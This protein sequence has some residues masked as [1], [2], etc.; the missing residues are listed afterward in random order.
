MELI[1]G[2]VRDNTHIKKPFFHQLEALKK[3]ESFYDDIT[4]KRSGLISIPTGGGKTFTAVRWIYSCVI[5]K[6]IKVIWLVHSIHLLEQAR[7]SFED[8]IGVLDDSINKLSLKIVSSNKLHSSD[9]QILEDDDILIITTPTAISSLKADSSDEAG[10][11][12]RTFIQKHQE[13]GILFVIDE[14]HHVP[15]YGC[16]NLLLNIKEDYKN[17]WMLGLT[18]TPTYTDINKRGW[19]G[20]IFDGGIIYGI[21]V[22]ILQKQ[23][24]LAKEEIFYKK[25]PVVMEVDEALFDR[26]VRKHKDIPEDIIE[27]LA[28]STVRNEF[29]ASEYAANKSYYGKTIIFLDRWFQCMH[30]K[31]LLENAG[32]RAEAVYYQRD[33]DAAKSEIDDNLQVIKNFKNNEFEVLLNIRML[34][35]G[36]DIPDVKTVFITRD[37]TSHILLQQMIGRALRG[38]K[39]GGGKNKSSAKI[40]MVGDTW[41]RKIEW[42]TPDLFGGTD[43]TTKVTTKLPV[44]HISYSLVQAL[45]KQLGEGVVLQR[46]KYVDL[47]PMGWYIT[48]FVVAFSGDDESLQLYKEYVLAYKNSK[49]ALD[50]MIND[51]VDFID[52]RWAA[53]SLESSFIN[54]EVKKLKRQYLENIDI[55]KEDVVR[56]CRHVAQNNTA[57]IFISFDN[58]ED[59]DLDRITYDMLSLTPYGQ[60]ISLQKI[61]NQSGSLWNQIYENFFLFKTAVDASINRILYLGNSGIDAEISYNGDNSI[62]NTNAAILTKEQVK[63]IKYRDNNTCVCCG[64]TS[65]ETRLTAIPIYMQEYEFI[66]TI[67]CYQTLCSVCASRNKNYSINYINTATRLLDK[68]HFKGMPFDVKYEKNISRIKAAIKSSINAYFGCRAVWDVCF[69]RRSNSLNFHTCE[70]K[71]FAHNNVQWLEADLALLLYYINTE[72]KQ[73][74]VNFIKFTVIP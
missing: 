34:A 1:N 44:Q 68:P 46:Q 48:E 36:T 60:M 59:V 7:K 53:E 37:T 49:D 8:D 21:S 67:D 3:M 20:I 26:L 64:L 42:A 38:E 39:A 28:S 41:K 55:E 27:K 30:I 74:Q 22:N 58:T 2:R 61:Y 40:V 4:V 63:S 10:S 18:A 24:I 9:A 73:S 32:I 15:A 50:Y 29:I 71:L 17:I 52:E 72:L 16:R 19:L 35:E 56:I 51:L 6:G 23:K 31:E 25:T 13:T 33:R 11:R 66:N 45:V 57:P 69:S 62:I 65:K 14:A 54:S 70:I 12:L 47:L 43:E 5:P